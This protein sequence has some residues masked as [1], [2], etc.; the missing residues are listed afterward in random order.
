MLLVLWKATL[1]LNVHIKD[2][3]VYIL[4]NKII[5]RKLTM[6]DLFKLCAILFQ[7]ANWQTLPNQNTSK[8]VC[9]LPYI[10][11]GHAGLQIIANGQGL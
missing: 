7:F 3:T 2:E 4:T 6:F 11:K 9:N 1:F 10:A 8:D 5:V